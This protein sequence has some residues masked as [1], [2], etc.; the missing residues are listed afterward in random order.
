MTTTNPTDPKS[1]GRAARDE[2]LRDEL[3]LLVDGDADA[4]ARHADHL[5]D[6]DAARDLVHDARRVAA[7]VAAAGADYAPDVDHE[8]ALIRALVARGPAR[9]GGTAAGAEGGAGATVPAAGGAGGAGGSAGERGPAAA[10]EAR[11]AGADAGDPRRDGSNGPAAAPRDLAAR[12]GGRLWLVGL[13]IAAAFVLGATVV[14]SR[15]L[16][17]GAR[18]GTAGSD[19]GGGPGRARDLADGRIAWVVRAASDGQT[20]VEA[21]LPGTGTFTPLGADAI[22]VAGT[23]LRT[24]GRT[25]ARLDLSDGSSL[26]VD[27]GSELTL[28]ADRPRGVALTR[29]QLLA[30]VAHLE[31]APNATFTTPTAR[32]EV[33]GTKLLVSATEDS[34]SVRVV[35]GEVRVASLG[36]ATADVRA[37]EEAIVGKTG[38]PSVALASG[39]SESVAWSEPQ[40][41]A[42]AD[43]PAAGLGE[44]RARRPGDRS[45]ER[46][47]A[48]AS[49]KVT[50]R[51]VGNVARTEIE[52]VFRNDTGHELEG[53]YRF[54]LPPDAR[55]SRLALDVDGKM[56]EGA[57][58]EKDRA[59]KIW[60][61]VI[62]NATRPAERRPNEE[63]VWVPGP[64][65]DP[66]L[67]EWQRGGR[68]ELRIFPIPARGER[69][70]VIG[71]TQLLPRR[72]DGRRYVYPLPFGADP[73]L[74]V[75]RFE[76]DA[77][78]AGAAR[79]AAS[80]YEARTSEDDGA[81]RVTYAADGF[82]PAGDLV[83]DY[84]EQGADA[85]LRAFTYAGQAA[86]PPGTSGGCDATGR[87]G[88]G[89][90]SPDQQ[91]ACNRARLQ[92]E[93][94]QDAR[95]YVTFVVRPDLPAFAE[96]GASDFVFVV[97]ASQSMVGE[98]WA[99][100]TRLVSRAVQEM[101][102][103]DRFVVLACDATCRAETVD[104]RTPGG[105]SAAAV[106]S[107]M[108]QLRP[109]GS[110]DL[111]ASLRAGLRALDG[112]R[113]AGR[114]LRLVYVGDGLAT[115]GHRRP[116][117]I[118]A[119]ATALAQDRTVSI[120]TV[121]IG[122]DA[123]A[124]VLRAVARGG[125]GHYVPYVPGERAGA[126]AL[127]VLA[128]S[129]GTSLEQPEVTLPDGLV[130]AAPA[131][132]PTVRAGEELVISARMT[133]PEV[134]G[135]VVLRGKVAGQPYEDRY[136][137][138]LVPSTSAGN[139]FVPR[140]WAAA[141]LEDLELGG[142]PSDRD[143]IVALSRGFG[144]LSRETSLL[145]LESDRMF[146]AFGVD[147]QQQ[148]PTWTGEDELDATTADGS[149]EQAQATV[150]EGAGLGGGGLGSG[151]IGTGSSAGPAAASPGRVARRGAGG[152]APAD[153]AAGGADVLP[154]APA[155]RARG[156]ADRDMRA[157]L[158]ASFEREASQRRAPPSS[159]P[160][161]AAPAESRA[162]PGPMPPPM[163][164][165][166]PG[167]GGQWMRRVWFKVGSVAASSG[168]T[169]A[170][171]GAVSGAEAALAVAPDSRDRHRAL[172]RALS[173]A[174]DVR[175]AE[176]VADRWLGRDALDAEALTYLADAV[177]RQGRRDDAMRLLTGI[178]D[179]RPDD[180][181]LHERLAKAFDRAGL[182]ERA[183]AHR[184]ALA[185]IDARDTTAVAAAVRCERAL[186]RGDAAGRLLSAVSDGGARARVESQALAAPAAER[187]SGELTVSATWSGASDVDLAIITPQGT[188]ISWM[189]GRANVFAGDAT[190]LGRETLGLR[191]ANVGSYV[192]EVV[193]AKPGDRQTVTGRVDV[194]VL[195]ERRTLPFTLAG[196]RAVVGRVEVR[197]ESRLE[198]VW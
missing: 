119:E 73:S 6:D 41:A 30:D 186:G 195:G 62:R 128:T 32:V 198:R 89:A 99:R 172:V 175:R 131:R 103:R 145:V 155:A 31:G 168:P 75:G 159:A 16:D 181:A 147:R 33:L 56:E 84:A 7:E 29:G 152:H 94:A 97:D 45:E 157:E 177:A 161:G 107:W 140:Q 182:S 100:A 69:R 58:V 196:E 133:K 42:S 126:A 110:S 171:Q 158:S 163:P 24:D 53:I 189:G 132:L 71:Y 134:T 130:D 91:A 92:A 169:A 48:L 113:G 19:P 70:I 80:G 197:R 78:V 150:L 173:R 174:G 4:R 10:A 90:S 61:G 112:K 77:R 23:T 191:S 164:P 98:R 137:V 20:G 143:R 124:A 125:G 37:G 95:G 8:E 135:E 50:V 26:V 176:E 180:K 129:Y 179:L 154:A 87:G 187:S 13:G 146:Q 49:H 14:G 25:R 17:G 116:A 156:E 153:D 136:P 34:T 11:G 76:V 142:D 106:E 81:R 166:P 57:F 117:S 162:A 101:D 184:V 39:L 55:I 60:R 120:S 63:Y 93:L 44:L 5:A 65:R 121:G 178:V 122:A 160:A 165:P 18:E 36:G 192:L 21:R 47:L 66:A 43:A 59:A 40:E 151:A 85:E 167:R 104:P 190:T 28:D 46:P 102:R 138:R 22:L 83:I 9:E 72:G 118:A 115:V 35:R 149:V 123:D 67:L 52:E 188:R 15:W 86:V 185:E 38:A 12:G 114:T 148:A 108:K 3:A 109:A 2:L 1:A 183:C 27:H 111:V 54:P 105:A 64:W 68:F 144:V 82:L 194:T 139:L 51:I 96:V 170:E 141:T 127:A 79:V 74:R 88:A 193:R